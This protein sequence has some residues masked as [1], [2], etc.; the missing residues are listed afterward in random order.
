MPY[1]QSVNITR[2]FYRAVYLNNLPMLQAFRHVLQ[3]DI[4]FLDSTKTEHR[5]IAMAIGLGNV[6]IPEWSSRLKSFYSMSH[7]KQEWLEYIE[8]LLKRTKGQQSFYVGS[9]PLYI[10]TMYTRQD[11]MAIFDLQEQSGKIKNIREGVY[12]HK[13]LNVDLFF[14]TLQKHQSTS[15]PVQCMK[16]ILYRQSYSIG[17]LK[18]IHMMV[19]QQVNGTSV[20][21][22]GLI[23]RL[24]S[25][26]VMVRK[27]NK[28][29]QNRLLVWVP[30]RM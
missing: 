1:R 6:P 8:L 19:Q 9:K 4:V 29:V 23:V 14:V 10:S 15:R 13:V 3:Q 28:G 22:K 30:V 2:S 11:V 18:A 27:M 20:L 12:H 21:L 25:L 26:F 16:I 17:S 5:W 7:L 24:C